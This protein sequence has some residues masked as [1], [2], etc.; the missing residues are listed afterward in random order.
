MSTGRH[1]DSDVYQPERMG[2]GTCRPESAAIDVHQHLW[3]PQFIEELRRRSQPPMLRG[4]TLLTAGEAPYEIDPDDHDVPRRQQLDR[5]CARVLLSM[6]AP[7][8]V[9]SLDPAQAQPLLNAWHHGVEELPAP[10]AGWAAVSETEPDL[11]GLSSVLKSN[12]FVGLQVSATALADPA[13]VESLAPVLRR[14]EQLDKPVLVHPGPVDPPADPVSR[15]P[16][17]WPAIVQYPAQLQA[18]WWA[19]QVAGPALLP[20]LRICFVAGAG[21]AAVHHERFAA[22][23]GQPATLDSNVYV[24]TSSYGRQAIDALSRVLGIDALVLGS[25]R[26]YATATNPQLGEAAWRAIS[27]TNPTRLLEGI[28]R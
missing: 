11:D 7:L 24:E 15:T 28:T 21:L 17:W 10:F 6:S 13:A 26:P 4:W 12:L 23:S 5:D 19:W 14:C 18:A 3:P 16:S 8:G 27:V 9:Q 25:D 1:G 22:R 20:D 2:I